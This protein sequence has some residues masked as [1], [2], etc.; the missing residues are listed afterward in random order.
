MEKNKSP[1]SLRNVEYPDCYQQCM[2]LNEMPCKIYC[3]EKLRKD[4]FKQLKTAGLI[5]GLVILV[6]LLATSAL[7]PQG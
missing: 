7:L 6:W 3:P 2:V 4:F 1:H 5:F